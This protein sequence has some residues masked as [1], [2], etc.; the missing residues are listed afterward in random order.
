MGEHVATIRGVVWKHHLREGGLMKFA[1][2]L[3]IVVAA[4]VADVGFFAAWS[5]EFP[6]TGMVYNTIDA[7]SLTHYCNLTDKLSMDCEFTQT[8]IRRKLSSEDAAKKLAEA[9]AEFIS[10]PTT[11]NQ[12]ECAQYETVLMVLQGKKAAPNMQGMSKLSAREKA[13]ALQSVGLLISFCRDPSLENNMKLASYGIEKDKRTCLISSNHFTQKF[14]H[15]DA[16]TWTVIS[17]PEGPCGIVQLSRFEADRQQGLTFWNYIAR[18]AVTN[19]NADA[20][21]L[22]CKILDEREYKYQ[23][24]TRQPDLNCEYVEFNPI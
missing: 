9:K 3:M 8:S 24:Q 6:S 20:G 5:Q 19:P 21:L 12:T 11:M 13:D 2:C 15:S 22:S 1:S 7:A 14:R 23:W 17:Q 18:K 10:K 4:S 16:N